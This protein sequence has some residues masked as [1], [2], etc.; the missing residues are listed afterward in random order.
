VQLT[1]RLLLFRADTAGD[2]DEEIAVACGV[3]TAERERA[4]EIGPD[5][6][7]VQDRPHAAAE[8]AQEGVQLRK[9]RRAH[10]ARFAESQGSVDAMRRVVL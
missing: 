3:G 6:I 10:L 9:R 4:D 8:V 1:K 2:D 5:V 7:C